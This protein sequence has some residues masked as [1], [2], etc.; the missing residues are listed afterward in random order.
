[1]SICRCFDSIVM[2]KKRI[3]KKEKVNMKM[4]YLVGPCCAWVVCWAWKKCC[5]TGLFGKE[6]GDQPFPLS[7]VGRATDRVCAEKLVCAA[8]AQLG[9]GGHDGAG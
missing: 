3:G 7:M 9:I 2:K 6:A 8:I 4:T 5:S 1:M